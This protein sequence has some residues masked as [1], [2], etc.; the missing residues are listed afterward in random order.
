M[1]TRA[2]SD[3]FLPNP[4]YTGELELGELCLSAAEEP[5]SVDEAL[6]Q[7]PWRNAME[8]EMNS[9]RANG[10]WE[11]ATLPVGHRAIGLKWVY[12]VKRD[13]AGNV[14]KYKARLVAKGYA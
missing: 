8:E 11:L 4:K 9:I 6:E 10:T 5:A 13:P 3:I 7:A 2:Q 12:K 1:C 14:V